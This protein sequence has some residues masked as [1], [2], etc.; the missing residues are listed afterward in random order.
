VYTPGVTLNGGRPEPGPPGP[1]AGA[2]GH[3]VR[4]AVIPA[5]GLGTR[6]LPASKALPKEL[7]PVVDRPVIQYG[8]EEAVA[9]G[10]R[11]VILVTAA[12]K[13]AI[14]D[15]FGASPELERLLEGKGD[16]AALRELR[17]IAGLA[18]VCAVRQ[19]RP[20]GLGHAVLQAKDLVGE[21]PFTLFLPDDIFQS[22]DG[23][24]TAQLL[25][26]Y[27][28][29]RDPVLA[30]ER[31][32]LA[33]APRYGMLAVAE[34]GPRLFRVLDMVEKPAPE[35]AP[36]DLAIMGRYVLTPDVFGALEETGPGA[37]GEIQL[38]DGLQA[39][40]RRRP[41]YAYAYRG[42]RYDCGT[43]LG[44]LRATV[45]LALQRPDLGQD[46][47]RVLREALGAGTPTESARPDADGVSGIGGRA[48]PLPVPVR[49]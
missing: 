46:F 7:L 26:V 3:G 18:Q 10:M 23:P 12:H 41:V 15:H 20:L 22:E 36:S 14:E 16:Q 6:M 25:G 42:R 38:T 32:P 17:R 30:V 2:A 31:V 24:L 29:F 33:H 21:E 47:R 43:K 34:I 44:Y 35:D 13:G 48:D 19:P 40:L 39:L 5:A 28:R 45:E 1:A 4:K 9:S 49:P 27:E 8:V 11:Q 37:G